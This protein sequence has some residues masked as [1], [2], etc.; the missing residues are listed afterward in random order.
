MLG[1]NPGQLNPMKVFMTSVFG[2][3]NINPYMGYNVYNNDFW[4]NGYNIGPLNN[5]PQQ[6]AQNQMYN[7]V[8]KTTEGFNF[9]IPFSGQRTIEDLIL[10]FF[11]R[12]DQEQLFTQEGNSRIAFFYNA[13]KIE[14]HCKKK[15]TENFKTNISPVI[16]VIDEQGLIGA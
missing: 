2:N 15:V 9:N 14:Y 7:C 6:P 5:F 10:T 8:F 13:S 11:R 12:V 3:Q 1:I 4:K 16:M